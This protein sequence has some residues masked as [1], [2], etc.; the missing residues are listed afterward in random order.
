MA[1]SSRSP[2]SWVSSRRYGVSPQPAQAPEYSN[3]GVR[4]CTPRTSDASRPAG[5]LSGRVAKNARLRALALE[6]RRL[7][8]H[9]DRA[10]AGGLEA[11]RRAA[12]THSSQPVQSSTATCSV[13][14]RFGKPRPASGA[15]ANP[16]GAAASADS[17]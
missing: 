3:S 9:V 17:S 2:N 8:V 7:G 1:T 4:Y 5:L 10:D 13:N 15:D 12:S 16:G 11:A 14:R 6:E